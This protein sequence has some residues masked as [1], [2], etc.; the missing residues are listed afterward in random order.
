MHLTV[1]VFDVMLLDLNLYE[2]MRFELLKYVKLQR[3]TVEVIVISMVD[4]EQKAI[5]AFDLG[6]NGYI[7]KNSWFCNHA[8]AV[9]Q[10]AN[11]GAF[12]SPSL[13]R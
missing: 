12:M 2:G 5:I 6:A 13:S 7:V 4:D 11:G 10:V 9:L 1:N 8:Q 3:P